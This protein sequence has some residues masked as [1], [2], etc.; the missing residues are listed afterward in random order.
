ML[1]ATPAIALVLG[2]GALLPALAWT[3]TIA[4]GAAG[5]ARRLHRWSSWPL[6]VLLIAA[7]HVGYGAGVL[8]GAVAPRRGSQPAGAWHPALADD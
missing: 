4:A 3:A 1:L 7:V 2:P 6:A 5:V 8:R